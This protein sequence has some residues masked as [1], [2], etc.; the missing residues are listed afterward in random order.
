[1]KVR[2]LAALSMFLHV[3]SRRGAPHRRRVMPR[4]LRNQI[5]VPLV[6]LQVVA[7]AAIAVSSATL[8]A[9]RTE[10]EIV[11]RLNGVVAALGDASFPFTSS[12][13]AR[14]QGLSGAHF[15]AYDSQGHV[16]ATSFPRLRDKPPALETS[17]TAQ[18]V[19]LADSP[20]VELD[21]VRYIA[22]RLV[23]TKTASRSLLVLYPETSWRQARWE[24]VLPPL[25]LGGTILGLMVGSTAW[26]AQRTSRRIGEVQRQVARIAGGDFHEMEVGDSAA[27]IEDLIRSVNRMCVEL[28]AMQQ[29][30][31]R[32]ER[33][34]VLAQLAAGMAHQMRNALTGA[35][36]SVQLYARRHPPPDG[37]NSLTVALRQL[38]MMEEQV[39]AVLALGKAE[40]RPHEPIDVAAL[41]QDVYSLVEP[42]AEHA[43]VT[44]TL[45]PPATPLHTVGELASL[46]SAVLNLTLNAVEA[47][48]KGGQVAMA[49]S[50]VTAQAQIPPNGSTASADAA[51]G[52]PVFQ[53][54]GHNGHGEVIAITISDNGAGPDPALGES[55]VDP[56]VT[57]KEEGIGLG[58]AV[59]HEVAA[60]HGGRLC[61]SRRDGWTRFELTLPRTKASA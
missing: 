5:L 29:T 37:D 53:D 20:T 48:G 1:M 25:I 23:D 3:W 60:A 33:V 44:L 17:G 31:Q 55:L 38:K 24:A 54:Q 11:D 19:A 4:S 56:F 35:R 57:T 36:L 26:I 45:Q 30:I 18:L 49:A 61:W 32:S 7:T 39:R 46:R 47:A 15:I 16:T 52:H 22:T 58:L 13:L 43:R 12:V 40:E 51:Q 59:V 21:G 2:H 14:M 10:R 34:K 8:A 42:A 27:E 28:R 9:R 41:L 6:M 50:Q